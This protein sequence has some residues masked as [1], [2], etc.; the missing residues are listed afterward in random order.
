MNQR[1]LTIIELIWGLGALAIFLLL[2]RFIS[3]MLELNFFV[4]IA[5]AV[6]AIYILLYLAQLIADRRTAKGK[7]R[8]ESTQD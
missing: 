4:T 8:A 1:G 5:F 6:F 7:D 2:S 3:Q